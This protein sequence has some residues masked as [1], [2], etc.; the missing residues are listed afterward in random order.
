MTGRKSKNVAAKKNK[1]D[2]M[3]TKVYNRLAIKILMA[4]KAGGNNPVTNDQLAR[5]LRE[6]HS[7]KLPKDNIERALKKAD[8]KNS[9]DTFSSGEYEVFGL[10]GAHLVVTTLSDNANRAVKTI[11]SVVGKTE[12]AKMASPGSILFQFAKKGAIQIEGPYCKDDVIEAAIEAEVDDVDFAAAGQVL[13]CDGDGGSEEETDSATAEKALPDVI[14]TEPHLLSKLQDAL[15]ALPDAINGTTS[16][17]YMPADY[18]QA[19]SEEEYELNMQ[20][21]DSLTSLSDVDAVF[22][23]VGRPA[24]SSS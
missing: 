5:V 21:V 14:I 19:A 3:K 20:L 18:V 7:F 2:A 11:K 22:H 23:N 4:A 24:S 16:I 13:G 15:S 12:G 10:G 1:L 9:N 6:A 17:V 8:D